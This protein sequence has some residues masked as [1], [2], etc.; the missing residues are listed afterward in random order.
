MFQSYIADDS[1]D[2]K[3][4]QF[5]YNGI[6]ASKNKV[7]EF[8]KHNGHF[9]LDIILLKVFLVQ[10][11]KRSLCYL[12]YKVT[13]KE[14]GKELGDQLKSQQVIKKQKRECK[15]GEMAFHDAKIFPQNR[16]GSKKN[17]I[18][19]IRRNIN[20]LYSSLLINNKAMLELVLYMVFSFLGCFVISSV[21]YVV[22]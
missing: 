5:V 15:H 16:P 11:L 6:K 18:H 9:K 20:N 8:L 7:Y 12:H 4:T 14:A 10:I 21:R 1:C 17:I 19:P 2:K 3:L 13:R 22:S